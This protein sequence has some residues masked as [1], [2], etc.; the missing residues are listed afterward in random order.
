MLNISVVG[1]FFLR[2]P[3]DL[4]FKINKELEVHLVFSI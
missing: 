1:F 3:Q 2:D 4:V